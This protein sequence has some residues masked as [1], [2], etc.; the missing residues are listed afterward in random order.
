MKT[1]AKIFI[2]IGCVLEF[3]LIFPIIICICACNKMDTAKHKTELTAL[4]VVTLLFCSLLGGIFMLCIP[5]QE[6]AL[7]SDNSFTTIGK[8][9]NDYL[10]NLKNL[11]SLYD[12]GIITEEIYNEKRKKYIEMI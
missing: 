2:I 5:D 12:N 6:L 8:N 4:G 1:A 10:Q 11:K 3:Y 9:T 7:N